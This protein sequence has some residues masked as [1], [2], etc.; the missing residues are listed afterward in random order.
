M[1]NVKETLKRAKRKNIL[2]EAFSR[3]RKKIGKNMTKF[4]PDSGVEI[5]GFAAKFY[6]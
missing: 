6:G 4:Y 1:N 2:K 5:Q 3:L